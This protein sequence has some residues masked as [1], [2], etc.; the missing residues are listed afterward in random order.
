MTTYDVGVNYWPATTAMGWWREF[1][2]E[3]F[4]R[5]ART[6]A[7]AGG[8]SVRIFLLWEVFQPTADQVSQTALAHLAQVADI[9]AAHG[10]AL[11]PTLFTGHMSGANWLPRWATEPGPPGRFP[12]VCDGAYAQ[13]RA[14]NWFSDEDV[15]RA[16]ELLARQAATAL[17]GHPALRAWDLGNENS[18]VCIPDTRDA[19][20]T[21]LR[22]MRDALRAGDPGCRVTIGLHMEDLEQDR[23]IGPA[24]AAEFCDFL[25]M[26]GYPLYAPWA[27]S[28]TDPTLPAFLAE[29]T[30]WLGGDDK[31]VFF[32]E[33]GMPTPTSEDDSAADVFIAEALDLLY[34]AGTTGAMLWCFSD[35]VPALWDG[36]PLDVAPHER[37][38]GLW[39]ANGTAKPA[40][41]HLA[42]Y[43]NVQ[44]RSA[45]SAP[46]PDADRAS[47]YADPLANLKRLYEGYAKVAVL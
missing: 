25:C 4:A 47:F 44:T 23:R 12:V 27:R 17:R 5:D 8:T 20:R 10:L 18:N 21:W 34:E 45:R 15:I 30:R 11:I 28:R 2:A 13:A 35:Y 6:I 43:A 46:W 41:R 33:F 14:R 7:D 31:D 39:R 19:G 42:R 24:E 32:E 3:E 26:H 38:F 40:A 29:V 9:C 16:Q 37:F 36:P 22:R 1:R